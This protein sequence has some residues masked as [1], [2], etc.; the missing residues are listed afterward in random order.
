LV[1][2]PGSDV[3]IL[4]ET[5]GLARRFAGND[6]AGIAA[7]LAATIAGQAFE[8]KNPDAYAWT[9]IAKRLDAVLREAAVRAPYHLSR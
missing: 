8:H 4:A 3:E 5:T 6:V 9:T 1:A 2:P 7:F